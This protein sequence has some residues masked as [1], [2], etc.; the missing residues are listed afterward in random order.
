MNK[1]FVSALTCIVLAM[2]LTA[3]GAEEKTTTNSAPK[4]EE[5][6]KQQGTDSSIEKSSTNDI[7]EPVKQGDNNNSSTKSSSSNGLEERPETATK[8]TLDGYLK[9]YNEISDR[10]RREKVKILP[11]EY[12][13]SEYGPVLYSLPGVK[14]NQPGYARVSLG[15][16]NDNSIATIQFDG[17]LHE[18]STIQAM[19]EATGIEWDGEALEMV[20]SKG[21]S[22]AQAEKNVWSFTV[23]TAPSG[24]S[25]FLIAL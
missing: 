14:E 10:F 7:K 12:N 2:G 5:Q 19:V 23:S 25:V 22:K 18:M 24:V 6:P 13:K 16:N 20:Q 17:S 3:C 9:K 8:V 4:K 21:Q 11:F 1:K 15:L